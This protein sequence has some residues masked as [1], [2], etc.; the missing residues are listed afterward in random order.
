MLELKNIES[1]MI[2]LNSNEKFN[3]FSK[4][5]AIAKYENCTIF[6]EILEYNTK[7]CNKFKFMSKTN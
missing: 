7:L 2:R 3:I 6:A 5:F 1:I 4:Q